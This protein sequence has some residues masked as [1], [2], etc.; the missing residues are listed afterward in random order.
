M[1]STMIGWMWPWW[2]IKIRAKN[3]T[4]NR[5]RELR[6]ARMDPG[7]IRKKADSTG[8]A[9]MKT[10]KKKK[11]SLREETEGSLIL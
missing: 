7:G 11:L 5:L 6:R 1:N 8:Q 2:I 3:L 9:R 10:E 4:A